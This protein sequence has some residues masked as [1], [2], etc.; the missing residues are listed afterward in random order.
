MHGLVGLSENDHEF[1]VQHQGGDYVRE[2]VDRLGSG[3][4]SSGVNITKGH[5]TNYG[6]RYQY[7]ADKTGKT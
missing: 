7:Q 2:T 5:R 4:L 3:T 6:Y 1:R